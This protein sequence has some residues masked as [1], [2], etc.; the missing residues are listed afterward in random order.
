MFFAMQCLTQ[1]L[2]RQ[3]LTLNVF[4]QQENVLH[5]IES[6]ANNRY[7]VQKS[8]KCQEVLI[9]VVLTLV[10]SIRLLIEWDVGHGSL[11][12]QAM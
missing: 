9:V 3:C 6:I 11:H 12:F 10:W 7:R 4:V 5:G 2:F 8:A 1:I